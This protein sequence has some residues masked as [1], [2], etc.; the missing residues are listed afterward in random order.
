MRI[1][2]TFFIGL[3]KKRTCETRM[4]AS[5]ASKQPEEP[6]AFFPGRLSQPPASNHD[7]YSKKSATD[8]GEGVAVQHFEIRQSSLAFCEPPE[9]EL[10]LVVTTFPTIPDRVET[11]ILIIT[12]RRNAFTVLGLIF[13]RSAISL[14]VRP[15]NKYS[16]ASCSRA[17]R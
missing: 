8:V 16:T 7:I 13:I 1:V 6:R 4:M 2:G 3:L 11:P 15:L 14:L 5:Y 12:T 10:G 9:S 17:E